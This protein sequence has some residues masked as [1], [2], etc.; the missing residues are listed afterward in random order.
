MFGGGADLCIANNCHMTMES[1]SNFPHSYHG[2][3]S[4]C[5]IL[6]GDYN[7]IV[8]DYEVFSLAD[9]LL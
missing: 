3:R 8:A 9:E 2:D 6:M 7:F 5:S 4:L 1:Y